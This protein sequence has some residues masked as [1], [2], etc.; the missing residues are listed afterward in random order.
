MSNYLNDNFT[1]DIKK[2]IEIDNKIQ[3]LNETLKTLR[4]S[5]NSTG[6]IITKYIETHNLTKTKFSL[7]SGY[8]KYSQTN[9]AKPLTYK[10][11]FECLKQYFND[12]ELSTNVCEFIKKNRET[13][14]TKS[15][16]RYNK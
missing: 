13:T 1:S 8:I 4:N 9:M 10:Y 16:K 14:L 3:S 2:W 12:E 11:I 5:R 7:S 15:I 6:E